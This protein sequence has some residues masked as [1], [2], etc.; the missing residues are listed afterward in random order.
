LERISEG[1]LILPALWCLANSEN[2]YLSTSELMD[3]LRKILKP[4]GEDLELLSGREDDKFSQKV[5]NLKSHGTLEKPGYVEYR[6]L[7]GIGS[8]KITDIGKKYLDDN[9]LGFLDYLVDSGFDIEP[10]YI[11]TDVIEG[12]KGSS[13]TKKKVIVFDENDLIIEGLKSK[14]KSQAYSRSS[15]LRD[16]ATEHYKFEGKIVCSACGFDFGEVYGDLGKGYIE[17]HHIK[18][19][20][21]YDEK[22]IELT[23]K[24]ALENVA[25]LCSNCHRMV[26]RKKGHM[27]D[28]KDLKHI[29]DI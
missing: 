12:K 5:R 11:A 7:D 28:I 15:K 9:N 13:T 2:E 24:D 19:V 29:L 18:P 10:F 6:L 8:W 1:D 16:A 23:I 21:S 14:N 26:H 27:L 25:P 20:F 3:L 4:T 22:D 17:I